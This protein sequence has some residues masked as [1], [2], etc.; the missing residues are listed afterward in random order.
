MRYWW[1]NGGRRETFYA[2]LVLT[3]LACLVKVVFLSGQTQKEYDVLKTQV[4]TNTICI[5]TVKEDISIIKSDVRV[6][7]TYITGKME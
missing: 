4:H 2:G 6:I 7:K 5:E 3:V 1:G